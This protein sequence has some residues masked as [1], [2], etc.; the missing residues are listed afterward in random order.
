M[1][2]SHMQCAW[3]VTSY[4]LLSLIADHELLPDLSAGRG[5]VCPQ[6]G[7]PCRDVTPD[8]TVA[9]MRPPTRRAAAG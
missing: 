7:R 1:F 6:H 4:E 2:F 9:G 5:V 3:H 8:A